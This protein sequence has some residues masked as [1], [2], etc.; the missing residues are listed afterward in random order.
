MEPTLTIFNNIITIFIILSSLPYRVLHSV[1]QLISFAIK[2]QPLS[3]NITE[4][5]FNRLPFQIKWCIFSKSWKT[6]F[7]SSE[8]PKREKSTIHKPNSNTCHSNTTQKQ[9]LETTRQPK[10]FLHCPMNFSLKWLLQSQR[11]CL[12]PLTQLSSSNWLWC[13][14]KGNKTAMRWSRSAISLQLNGWFP[15][16]RKEKLPAAVNHDH[17]REV[18]RPWPFDQYVSLH[19]NTK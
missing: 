4:G 3:R 1:I 7:F 18:T 2:I 5:H 8:S 14:K 15:V 10:L 19:V 13:M 9:C 17:Y 12:H 6:L 16:S 11:P